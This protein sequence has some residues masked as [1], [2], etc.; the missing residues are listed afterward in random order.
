MSF[1]ITNAHR[2]TY[3]NNI[4]L[5]LQQMQ[6]KLAPYATQAD[7]SGDKSKIEDIF[8]S[9]K[10]KRQRTRHAQTEFNNVGHDG[11]WI[12][13]TDPYTFAELV[14]KPD[15]RLAPGIDIAGGYTKVGAA[16]MN[17]APDDA[18]LE[19]FYGVALTGKTGSTQVPFKSANIC[20]VTVG[21]AAAT[22]LNLEKVRWAR[23][24]LAKGLVDI[25]ADELYMAITAEQVDDLYGELQVTSQEFANRG[26]E[27]VLRNG[28]L[29]RLFRFNFVECEYGNE[30]SFD[31]YG[32]TVDGSGYRRVPY[33][34]KSGMHIGWWQR[35]WADVSIRTDLNYATQ[36]YA[37]CQVSAARTDEDKVGQILCAE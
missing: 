10:P 20:P 8:G 35:P 27:P 22:G 32:L 19:G 15:Q 2:V 16:T 3:N 5:A 14:D 37:A 29:V 33:W 30:A 6:S 11:R 34:A 9:V 7:Y 17:R 13:P 4:R 12:S 24:Q 31:S 25:E 26:E 28:R 36:V 18:F 23:K 1:Q 21:A